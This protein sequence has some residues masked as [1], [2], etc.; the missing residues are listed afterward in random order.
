MT[1]HFFTS[2]HWQQTIPPRSNLMSHRVSSLGLFTE[3][4]PEMPPIGADTGADT[5]ERGTLECAPHCRSLGGFVGFP[6]PGSVPRPLGETRRK[7]LPSATWTCLSVLHC[8]RLRF[9]AL[10]SQPLPYSHRSRFTVTNEPTSISFLSVI[11]LAVLSSTGVHRAVTHLSSSSARPDCV[12][13][14]P[15]GTGE[16]VR[17]PQRCPAVSR[18]TQL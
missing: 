7:Q 18:Q 4:A 10:L 3:R 5:S 8:C 1:K 14:R 11:Y 17:Q 12:T 15:A 6:G 9:P 2:G 13:P 16:A